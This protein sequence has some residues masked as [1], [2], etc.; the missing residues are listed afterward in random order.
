MDQKTLREFEWRC[1]QEEPPF[2]QGAC[3]IHVDVRGLTRAMARGDAQAARKV[4]A[5][6]MPLP[7]VLGLICDHPCEASCRRADVEQAIRIGELE[8]SCI[9]HSEDAGRVPPLPKRAERVA[10]HGG[11]FSSLCL[12]WDLVRKG[13]GV[14][15]YANRIGGSLLVLTEERLPHEALEAEM[16]T[17]V[18]MGVTAQPALALSPQ[19]LDTLLADHAAVYL[20]LDDVLP[21]GPA[22]DLSEL[23]LDIEQD[24]P[25]VDPVSLATSRPGVYAGGW[26]EGDLSPVTLALDG[27]KVALSIERQVQGASLTASRDKEGPYR[28]RQDTPVAGVEERSAAPMA[29][30]AGYVL[31]EA[32]AEAG[33]CLQCD[34][35]RCVHVCPYLE[36][37]KAWPKRY[38]REIYNN[39]SVIH[40]QRQANTMINS[41]SWCRLCEHVCPNDFN[42]AELTGLARREMVAAGK[43]PPSAHEFALRDFAF[44]T[45]DRASL[46]RVEPVKDGCSFLFFPGCQLTGSSPVH[47][48]AVYNFLRGR[49]QGGVGLMLHCCGAPPRWA[50]REDL[51]APNNERIRE[52][53]E[54]FGRPRLVLA[55]STCATVFADTLPEAECVSLWQV[56]EETGLPEGA[57]AK[58]D[59]FFLHDPCTTRHLPA[60]RDSVRRLVTQLGLKVEEPHLTAELTECCGYGGLMDCANPGMARE[61]AARRASRSDRKHILAYCAMCRDELARGDKP[62]THLL[63]LLFPGSLDACHPQATEPLVR[64]GRGMADRQ[65]N[66]ARLR[67]NL[68]REI[69][70]EDMTREAWE[71]LNLRLDPEVQ[72]LVDTRRILNSD[73]R[74]AIHQAEDQGNRLVDPD[75]GRFLAVHRPA[76]VTYWVEYSPLVDEP[77]GYNVHRAWSHRMQLEVG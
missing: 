36:H 71:E 44:S 37:Y 30:P 54:S 48:R 51:F 18:R 46:A 14:D 10:V 75:T 29:D 31:D 25:R 63:D 8:R 1:I 39:L 40:G 22:L 38:V 57:R 77:G 20:G 16:A 49:L 43:M 23:G 50:G 21:D 68:L 26:L 17:L 28:T 47:V 74:R 61:Q 67:E 24:R 13:F 33:R 76:A 34:C 6:T 3:P 59:I 45:S 12:A 32:K 60:Y 27:R 41:C 5:K 70:S 19:L 52:V 73:L 2:C 69:W 42:M 15:L 72:D 65:E 4:L 56:L 55:C 58:E 53:W 9:R 35:M 62:V 66:R 11:G 64:K 7:G